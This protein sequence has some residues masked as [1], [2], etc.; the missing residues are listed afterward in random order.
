MSSI[1]I[2]QV[3]LDEKYNKSILRKQCKSDL[4]LAIGMEIE[5]Y[6]WE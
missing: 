6:A 5:D 2:D 1:I 4:G 3:F